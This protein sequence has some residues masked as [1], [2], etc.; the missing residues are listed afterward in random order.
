MSQQRGRY[1]GPLNGIQ[2][3]AALLFPPAPSLHRHVNI[4]QKHKR[5]APCVFTC[6]ITHRWFGAVPSWG[7]R[8]RCPTWWL[9][10]PWHRAR[11]KACGRDNNTIRVMTNQ[12]PTAHTWDHLDHMKYINPIISKTKLTSS[13]KHRIKSLS[14]LQQHLHLF[15]APTCFTAHQTLFSCLYSQYK[16]NKKDSKWTLHNTGVTQL[17]DV[18]HSHR[19][20]LYSIYKFWWNLI[21]F[22]LCT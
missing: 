5:S 15:A 1:Q 18:T 9:H 2:P 4:V 22:L 10:W 6:P 7:N 17:H 13:R 19:Y 11:I 21:L 8:W 12:F 3:S 14:P 20:Y 16:K